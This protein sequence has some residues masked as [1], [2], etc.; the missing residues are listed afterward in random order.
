M[1]HLCP[2][3]P[4][5]PGLSEARRRVLSPQGGSWGKFPESL[6][7]H[8]RCAKRQTSVADDAVRGDGSVRVSVAGAALRPHATGSV[9]AVYVGSLD[10]Q[11]QRLRRLC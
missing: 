1:A 3:S 2:G 11:R 10:W 6:H 4:L 8:L 9:L 7:R 5:L